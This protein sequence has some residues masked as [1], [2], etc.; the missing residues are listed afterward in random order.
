MTPKEAILKIQQLFEEGNQSEE[1]VSKVEMAEY[2]L[3]D[4]TKLM[5][6]SLEVG[7][8]VELSDGTPAPD[9]SHELVDG[10][11]ISVQAGKITEV[12]SPEP[13]VEVE[14]E[15]ADKTKE[16]EKMQQYS[17]D[18]ASLK[19]QNDKLKSE[20]SELQNK[21][22]NGFS[23]VISLIEEIS[24]IP[25]SEPIEKQNSFKFQEV[26]DI[27][28]ERLNRYRNAILNQKN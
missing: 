25:Q 2:V 18:I 15:S 22:K 21:I 5:I 27:K 24:K 23:Q 9:G 8:S 1:K 17:N 6:S 19:M 26:K 13:E 10:T 7:G 14:I 4:G 12:K 3:K 16:D 11:I 20:I 28:L